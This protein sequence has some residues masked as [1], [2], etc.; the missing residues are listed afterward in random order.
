MSHRRVVAVKEYN[1][2]GG[3]FTIKYKY[4]QQCKRHA[5]SFLQIPFSAMF[6]GQSYTFQNIIAED[7]CMGKLINVTIE[8]LKKLY[9]RKHAELKFKYWNSKL[10]LKY[11]S[12]EI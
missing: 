1:K 2:W 8:L 7:I 9:L 10:S 6:N 5:E 11:R 4:V 3:T 12:C